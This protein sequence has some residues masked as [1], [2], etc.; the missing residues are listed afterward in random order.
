MLQCRH[1]ERHL[2]EGRERDRAY[3]TVFQCHCGVAMGSDTD[4]V[5][6]QKLTGEMKGSDFLVT[7]SRDSDRLERAASHSIQVFECVAVAVQRGAPCHTP[8]CRCN[9]IKSVHLA[10]L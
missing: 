10:W 6:A 1:S 8:L 3:L 9:L 5:Q 2:L 7:V 4:G